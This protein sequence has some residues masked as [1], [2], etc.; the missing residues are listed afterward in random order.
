[1]GGNHIT[2]LNDRVADNKKC[3]GIFLLPSHVRR[4]SIE[5]VSAQ[6]GRTI[7][8][9]HDDKTVQATYRTICDNNP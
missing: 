4:A 9:V 6:C 5:L 3:A 7:R 8:S 1:M 2:G